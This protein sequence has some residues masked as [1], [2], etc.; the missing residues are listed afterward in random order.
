LK[1]RKE[2]LTKPELSAADKKRLE[3]IG[4]EIGDLP[5]GETAQDVKE[6]EEIRKTLDLLMRERSPSK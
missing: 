1:E 6:R 3:Q 4:S 2:L 5:T